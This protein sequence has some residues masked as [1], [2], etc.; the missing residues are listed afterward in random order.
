MTTD[1][2]TNAARTRHASVIRL[3]PEAEEE[4]RRIHAAVWPDV[5]RQIR[6]SN[7]HNYSIFLRDGLLFSY[8]EYAGTDHVGDLA[9]MAAD[10]RTREWWTV[11]DPLQE[12][13]ATA[14]VGQWWAPADEVFHT[15]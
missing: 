9:A 7:I 8:Y 15:D 6:D 14:A 1:T 12:P 13:V 10:P 4:Y 2:M 5:L 11:T 3:K